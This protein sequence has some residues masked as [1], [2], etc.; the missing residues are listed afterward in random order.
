MRALDEA[1]LKHFA[2]RLGALGLR[3]PLRAEVEVV[4]AAPR[5]ACD[6]TTRCCAPCGPSGTTWA[7]LPTWAPARPTRA[8]R[9][10]G[11][12]RRC[13]WASRRGAGMH[14]PAERIE[15]PPL[16]LGCR[17]L[18]ALLLDQLGAT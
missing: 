17:R 16:A 13:A 14:T 11:A 12:C 3:P 10:R 4:G 15:I 1:P 5:G 7:S 18:E 8:R 2:E 9:W 6:A